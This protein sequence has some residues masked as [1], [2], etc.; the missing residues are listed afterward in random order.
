MILV[1]HEVKTIWE[2][3][4]IWKRSP[5]QLFLLSSVKTSGRF[6]QIFVTFSEKLDFNWFK[7]ECFWKRCTCIPPLKTRQPILPS[8]CTRVFKVA[9]KLRM[10]DDVVHKNLEGKYKCAYCPKRFWGKSSLREHTNGVHLNTKPHK[11]SLCD[12]ASSYR[13]KFISKRTFTIWRVSEPVSVSAVDR[14]HLTS[15]IARYARNWFRRENTSVPIVQNDSGA[16]PASG[17]TPM[18]SI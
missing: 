9:A 14:R 2:S 13:S 1:L 15:F 3:H 12:F 8:G 4:K 17:N 11:C 6:S 7:N 16:S 18:A 5:K 10:H